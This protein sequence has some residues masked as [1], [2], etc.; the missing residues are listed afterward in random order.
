MPSLDPSLYAAIRFTMSALVLLPFSISKLKNITKDL[1]L[2]GSSA[3][4]GLSVFFAYYGQSIGLSTTT[5]NKSAFIC[6][7]NVV[8]VAL[9][10]SLL[11]KEFKV[12]TW[13]SALMA[14]LGVA[15]L[16]ADKASPPVRFQHDLLPSSNLYVFHD[17]FIV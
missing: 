9:L 3:I 7:L 4:M 10:S 14:V 12:Q 1:E 8:W 13:L 2:V 11:K 16:E 5:A 15:I 6:S 17:N